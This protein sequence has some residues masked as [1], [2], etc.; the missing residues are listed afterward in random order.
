ML[1][2]GMIM[3]CAL[4]FVLTVKQEHLEALNNGIESFCD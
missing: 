4:M 3:C 1:A 2:I